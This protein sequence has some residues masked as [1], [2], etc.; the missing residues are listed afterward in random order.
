MVKSCFN[1]VSYG[2]CRAHPKMDIC[3]R[4][5]PQKKFEENIKRVKEARY[6]KNLNEFIYRL[7]LARD[8]ENIAN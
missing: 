2:E 3:G 1:C 6:K 4:Y 7:K 8:K 5:F